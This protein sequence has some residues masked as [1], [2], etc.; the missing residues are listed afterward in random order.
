MLSNSTRVLKENIEFFQDS[1]YL[2]NFFNDFSFFVFS[3]LELFSLFRFFLAD[4]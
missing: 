1:N 4:N 3:L 2:S